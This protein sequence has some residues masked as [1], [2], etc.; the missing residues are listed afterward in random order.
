MAAVVNIGGVS[1][2]G[3]DGHDGYLPMGKT[4]MKASRKIVD[5]NC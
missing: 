3:R 1:H 4:M 2:G 5:K